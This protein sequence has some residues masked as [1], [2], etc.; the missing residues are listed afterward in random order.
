[1]TKQSKLE[2][3]NDSQQVEEVSDTIR[4]HLYNV[5][6]KISDPHLLAEATLNA[7]FEFMVDVRDSDYLF[8]L[9]DEQVEFAKSDLGY[10]G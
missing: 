9:M 6:Y 1:M 5:M 2:H 8:R 10:D 3:V 7:L 4:K